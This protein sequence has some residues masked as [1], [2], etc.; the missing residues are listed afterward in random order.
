M[1]ARRTWYGVTLC[2][3]G[4]VGCTTNLRPPHA[5]DP[6]P[7]VYTFE[8]RVPEVVEADQGAETPPVAA[9]GASAPP[10]PPTPTSAKRV[11]PARPNTTVEIVGVVRELS[12]NKR[13]VYSVV[14]IQSA[15]SGV[16]HSVVTEADG[17]FRFE[18]QPPGEYT[19][20]AEADMYRPVTR[21]GLI[22]RP[23]TRVWLDARLPRET[24]L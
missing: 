16:E 2:A 22:F 17:G 13:L 14:T 24:S 3:L 1:L 4:L 7:E 10:P 19:F 15:A 5:F 12:T 18:N 20:S 11:A 9:P 21:S 6:L 23:G 8:E